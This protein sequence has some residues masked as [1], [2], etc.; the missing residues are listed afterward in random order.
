MP[1]T[2][3]WSWS[4]T[5]STTPRRFRRP[6]RAIA[7]I[8]IAEDDLDTLVTLSRLCNGLMGR[9]RSNYRKI[10]G[11]NSLLIA[12]GIAEVVTPT[13]TALLHNTSTII[14]SLQSMKNLLPETK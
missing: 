10:I 13:T 5:V 14:F 3:K 1:P 2:A 9:I 7:D 6:T 11:F 12:L 8:T 4:A